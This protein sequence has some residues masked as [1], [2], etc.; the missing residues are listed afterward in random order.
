MNNLDSLIA[1]FEGLFN[2][3]KRKK[4]K[5]KRV[6]QLRRYIEW[7]TLT[8]EEK[9]ATK[10]FLLLPLFAYILITIFNNNFFF[11]I[12]LLTGYLLYRKFEKRNIIKK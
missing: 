11:I 5:M 3:Q 7:K 6:F 1:L 12:L 8:Y 4:R 10:R 2:S 9:L